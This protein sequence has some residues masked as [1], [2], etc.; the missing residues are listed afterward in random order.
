MVS[1]EL[2][3]TFDGFGLITYV[4]KTVVMP[5]QQVNRPVQH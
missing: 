1:V 5:C 2:E 4:S 3:E